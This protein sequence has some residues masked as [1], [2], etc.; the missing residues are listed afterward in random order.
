MAVSV[1]DMMAAANAVVERIDTARA[2]TLLDQGGLL[3]DVRDAVELQQS[4]RAAGAHHIPRSMLEFRADDALQSHDPELQKDRPVVLYCASGG[5]A[6]LAGKLLHDMGYE[7]IYN[8]GGL[9]DWVKGGGDVVD[10]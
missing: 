6:A 8:M 1:K 4:G 9:S 2:K 5:R 7:H 3:L 10:T